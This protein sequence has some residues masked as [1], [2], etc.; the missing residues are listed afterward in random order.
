MKQKVCVYKGC[1]LPKWCSTKEFACQFRRCR[2]RGFSPWVRKIPWRRKWQPTPVF[3]PGESHEQRSLAGYSPWGGTESDTTESV[4]TQGMWSNGI[5]QART[6]EW[7]ATSSSRGSSQPRDRTPF[8]VSLAL[9]A[10]SF[11]AESP[12]GPFETL[13][14]HISKSQCG[15]KFNNFREVK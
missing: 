3:L 6:L 4:H 15:K 10:D 5:S 1:G 11:T 8:P 9:Q 2:R 13:E 12:G 14:Q 7:I